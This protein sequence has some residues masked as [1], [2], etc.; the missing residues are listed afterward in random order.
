VR[1]FVSDVRVS[2]DRIVV[3]GTPAALEAA[4]IGTDRGSAPSVPSFDREWCQK[5]LIAGQLSD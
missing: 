4:L 1:L 3:P 2:R 5:S